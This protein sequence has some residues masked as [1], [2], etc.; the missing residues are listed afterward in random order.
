MNSFFQLDFKDKSN[1]QIKNQ[2]KRLL[3]ISFL[4][5]TAGLVIMMRIIELSLPDKEVNANKND[6]L[7]LLIFLML[8][9]SQI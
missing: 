7:W 6:S 3:V 8:L 2:A 5:A 9:R 1:L 4:M